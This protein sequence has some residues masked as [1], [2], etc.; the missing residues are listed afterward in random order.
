M[1]GSL[2]SNPRALNTS[3]AAFSSVSMPPFRSRAPMKAPRSVT[4]NTKSLKWPD[5]RAASWRLSVKPRS[6]RGSGSSSFNCN[7]CLK[8]YFS[9][10]NVSTVVAE[11]RPSPERLERRLIS[12][13]RASYTK[14]HRR[15]KLIRPGINQYLEPSSACWKGISWPAESM[16]KGLG[17]EFL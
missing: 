16:A 15:Q 13:P 9:I 2:R 7:S 3:S 17:I 4:R 6:L 8:R 5:C 12:F 14:P 11:E 10:E 1:P